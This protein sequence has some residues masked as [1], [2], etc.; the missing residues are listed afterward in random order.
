MSAAC[1][2]LPWL[3]GRSKAGADARNREGEESMKVAFVKQQLDS[4]GP[5]SSVRYADVGPDGLFDV[6]PGKVVLWQATVQLQADWYVV[7]QAINTQYT[8]DSVLNDSGQAEICQRYTRNM[9]RSSE[10]QF[11]EYDVVISFDPVLQ[12]PRGTRTLFAYYMHE[13]WDISYFRSLHR[14]MHGYDL[15]LA[16][17]MDALPDVQRLPQALSFPYI[18]NIETTRR[19]FGVEKEPFAWI[20]YRTVVA[21]SGGGRTGEAVE[22]AMARLQQM[23]GMLLRHRPLKAGLYRPADPPLW[24]DAR[25]YFRELAPAKYYIGVGRASG[26]GQ[27]LVDAASLGAIC[28]GEKDKPF[29]R[30]LCHPACLC[31]DMVDLPRQFRLVN[32]SHDLQT[33]ILAWQDRTLRAKFIDEPIALLSE[34]VVK[35]RG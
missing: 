9:V 29:Q 34:A 8:F 21:L 5:W 12:P 16:H 30:M 11:D 25:G 7:P 10:I 3:D 19:M 2:Y 13:H 4:F 18:W 28:F 20:D 23:L 35:K 15:F 27:S 31:D 32:A 17:M 26:G 24:G 1:W 22:G 14:V 6:W 33:E